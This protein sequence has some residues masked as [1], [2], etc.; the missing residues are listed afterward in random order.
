MAISANTI[1][2]YTEEFKSIL[3]ILESSSFKL[4]YCSE[5]IKTRGSQSFSFAVAMVSFC[6]IPFTDYKKHFASTKGKKLGYYGDYGIG[7]TKKWAKKNGLN[8]VFY[9]DTNSYAGTALRK[10]VESYY[11]N[12]SINQLEA[13][14][15]EET[16]KFACFTK[17]YEGELYRKGLLKDSKYKFYDER[18][19]RYVPQGKDLAKHGDYC[20]LD[21]KE[22]LSDK[23]NFTGKINRYE[24]KFS[25]DDISYIIVKDE[26]E[27]PILINTLS[28]YFTENDKLKILFTKIITSEQIIN[29]F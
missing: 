14:F 24:L 29:D 27:I 6:D 11:T 16:T 15:N 12:G 3:E 7:L 20:M 4:S 13:F 2:H 8:P 9:I 22:Y 18:E 26:N 10:S 5:R 17:N 25:I 19:W 23:Q 28:K 21:N 1:V